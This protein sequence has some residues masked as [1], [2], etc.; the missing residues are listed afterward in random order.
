MEKK[1]KIHGWPFRGQQERTGGNSAM[2]QTFVI[3]GQKDIINR[4]FF[5]FFLHF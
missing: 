2:D 1:K 3:S 4:F 5:F